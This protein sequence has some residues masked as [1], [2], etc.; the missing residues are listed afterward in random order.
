MQVICESP[1]RAGIPKESW[2]PI[3]DNCLTRFPEDIRN[4]VGKREF[5]ATGRILTF[6]L[7]SRDR[8]TEQLWGLKDDFKQIPGVKDYNI[9]FEQVKDKDGQ[10]ANPHP[11]AAKQQLRNASKRHMVNEAG[12]IT[13]QHGAA[14]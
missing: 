6:N 7:L 9:P 10:N 12:E 2:Q 1:N 13:N 5:N 3:I 14:T 8:L 4:R 11:R